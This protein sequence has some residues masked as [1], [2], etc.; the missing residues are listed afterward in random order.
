MIFSRGALVTTV[1]TAVLVGGCAR[2]SDVPASHS[3]GSG[4]ASPS[5]APESKATGTLAAADAGILAVAAPIA[6]EP[7]RCDDAKDV[8]LFVS[9]SVP[10]VGQ[11]LRIVAVTD[12]PLVGELRIKTVV[13]G[14]KAD[15]SAPIVTSDARHGGPPYFWVAEVPAPRAGGYEAS[16]VQPACDAGTNVST[17]TVKV[18]AGTPTA[19][20]APKEG[21]GLWPVRSVWSRHLENV[22]SAWIETL[23]DAPDGEMPSWPAL[24]ELLRDRKRNLLFDHLAAGEDSANAPVVRPDCADLPYF[25]RAYFAFK[26]RLPFGVSECNRGGGGAPPSCKGITTNDDPPVRY[27]ANTTAVKTFGTFLKGTLA[28]RAHSGSAR[29]PFDDENSDYYPVPLTW[30]SLRPGTVFADPYGHVLVIAKRLP[31]TA[32]RGGVLLAVDGQP[33]GTVARKRFWRGNFL[34]AHSPELGGPGFKRFRP[35][36]RQDKQLARLD[37]EAIRKHPEYGDVSREPGKLDIEP[38]YDAMDDVMSPRPL[39]PE[40]A[41]METIA[42]LEEQ[43]RTRVKSVDNGRKWLESAKAPATMPEGSEI[44]ETTGTWEDFSTPSRDLRLLIAIDVVRGFPARVARRPERYAMPA[45]SSAKDV[46]A[47]LEKVLA[48]ELA[49]RTVTYTRTDG[50][51]ASL[52]LADVASRSSALEMAYNP[53]DCV[54]SR[55]GPRPA[56]TRARP[57]RVKRLPISAHVWINAVRGSPSASAPRA[58]DSLSRACLVRARARMHGVRWARGGG[59]FECVAASEREGEWGLA[60]FARG[61]SQRRRDRAARSF[62]RG[63]RA[64]HLSARRVGRGRATTIRLQGR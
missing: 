34:Y 49:A 1:W 45:G 20:L 15:D 4:D 38:F 62:A 14:K 59:S 55:W 56:A 7:P 9:P 3:Q 43:V 57:A 36:V 39:D 6:E 2:G 46:Q 31:Q 17:R 23:F 18:S 21:D 28:D 41:L 58:S 29:T 54:E 32:E 30:D 10:A 35:L 37:D 11:P 60:S 22:Y 51:P 26:L 12:K 16:L 52:S 44:F 50:S 25:L 63:L 42:A 19:P 61:L 48:R 64:R 40:R 5:S 53:N 24:H 8:H 27:D 13:K 33:D 47:S